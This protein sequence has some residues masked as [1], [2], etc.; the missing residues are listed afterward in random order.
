M[1]SALCVVVWVQG[2]EAPHASG[3][4]AVSSRAPPQHMDL[5]ARLVALPEPPR[6]SREHRI[7]HLLG[8]H[9]AVLAHASRTGIESHWVDGVDGWMAGDGWMDG[10]LVGWDGWDGMGWDGMGWDGM[11][12]DGMGWVGWDGMVGMGWDGGDGMGWD[13]MDLLTRD[14]HRIRVA[15]K[16]MVS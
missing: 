5:H 16:P 15:T 1:P 9:T 2:D 13:A 10:W 14:L 4:L 7:G 11:G 8:S 6:I 3:N 12:W